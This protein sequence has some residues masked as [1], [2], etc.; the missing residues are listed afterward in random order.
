MWL[1]CRI[2]GPEQPFAAGN[3]SQNLLLKFFQRLQFF[4]QK[5]CFYRICYA[6]FLH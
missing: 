5:N 6:S 3:W 1:T 2:C 4:Y